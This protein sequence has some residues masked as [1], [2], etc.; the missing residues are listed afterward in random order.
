MAISNLVTG[1][2]LK[3]SGLKRCISDYSFQAGYQRLNPEPLLM[4]SLG[5]GVREKERLTSRSF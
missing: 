2:G 1:F 3:L 4:F 5:T